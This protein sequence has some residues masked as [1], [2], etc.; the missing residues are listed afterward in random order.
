MFTEPC[1]AV[2]IGRDGCVPGRDQDFDGRR[3][4]IALDGVFVLCVGQLV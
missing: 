2:Q 3:N 4:V 1:P